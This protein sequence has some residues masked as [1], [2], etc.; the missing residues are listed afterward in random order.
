MASTNITTFPGKVGISNANPTHTLAIG[1][2]VF[3]DDT[4]VNKLVVNGNIS[5]TGQFTGDGVG[6][7]NIQTSNV[8]GL[9]DNVTRIG[10]LETDLTDNVTRIG[11]LETDLTDNVTRIGTL[12]TDLSDNSSR[13]TSI[14]S[15]EITITGVKTFQDDIILESNLRVQ[16][17]LLVANTVNMTV[18][19]PILELGSNNLN[20]G[21]VGLVM[22][23]HGSANSNVAI[24]FDESE[25]VLNMGY[26]LSG[27][28]DTTIEL[29]SNALAVNIQGALTA[30]SV[31]GDGSGLTNIQ[32]SN[33][34]DFA[35]NVARITSLESGDMTIDGEKTFSS[36]LE[37]G[38]ANL[39]VD[40][41]TGFVGVGTTNPEYTL[42]VVGDVTVSSN[43]AV[44]GSKFTYDNT[45]TIVFTGT[46]ASVVA[47]E[48]GY[49]D[50][51][52]SSTSNNIRVKIFIQYTQSGAQGEAEYSY[53]IRPNS[54]NSSSIYDYIN[55]GGPITPV[56]YRTDADDLYS[57][58]TP[59]VVRFGYSII[60]AQFVNWR[61]EVTQRSNN[62][63]FYPT[64]TGLAVDGT[65]LIQVTPAPSTNLNSNLAVNTDTL[66]VD[67]TTGNVGI[68]TTNP[69]SNLH[70]V[71]DINLTS[72]I[73][74]SG[75]VFV[76]AHDATS[77]YVA[78][79]PG[80]GQTEQNTYTIAIGYQA[81]QIGQ[82][83]VA[84]AVGYLAGQSGQS[85]SAIAI[86]QQA[87]E[88]NQG[89]RAVAIGRE[90][91]SN[92]QAQY[93]IAIGYKAGED[94]QGDDAIAVGRGAGQNFQGTQAV[95][96]GY[97]AGQTNQHDNTVVI[98]ASGSA[99]NTEGTGRTY[100]KPLRVA[101]VASNVMTYDQTTGEVMDSGGLFTNRLAVV[102]E[103]PPAALTYNTAISQIDGHGKYVI[104]TSRN[105]FNSS[106]G[107]STSAFDPT[108]G[109]WWSSG[110][111]YTNG[112]ANTS[113]TFSSLTDSGGTTH[114][115]AWASLKLP[116]KT[117]LRHVKMNQRGHSSGPSTFP[118]AVTVLGSNDDGAT[119][120]LIQNAISVPSAA[121]YT[122]TQIVVDASEKYRTYYFS[123]PTL[124][125]STA[126][127]LQ[128]GKIRLFT[129]SFSV[130]GGIMTSTA[131]SDL[132][133]S[134]LEVT[135]NAYVSSNLTVGT[136]NL[137]V[138]TLTGRIGVG[139]VSPGYTLDVHGTSN[140]G[141]L[142]VT[143]V[144]GNGSGLT[145]L[146]AD[147]LGS[148]TVPSARLSLVASDIPSLDASKITAGTLNNARLNNASTTGAGIVQ[149]SSSTSGS[150]TTKAA[151]ESAVKA[152]Y[153]RSSW[154]SGTFSGDLAVSG[155]L[156]VSGT[157]T[158]V[159]TTNLT[160]KDTIVELGK[161]NT[162]PTTDLG[163]IMRRPGSNVG[164][165]YDGSASK[166]EIGHTLSGGS[167]GTVTMDTSNALAVNVNGALTATSLSGNG[168]GLTSLNASNLSSGNVPSARLSL[169]ASDIPSLD[170]GKITSGTLTRP[171]NT[172]TGVF[173]HVSLGTDNYPTLGGNWL[174]IF[175]PTY[176]GAIGDNHPDP[177]GGILFANRSG[178]SRFPWGYYMG[179][180][181]DVASTNSTSLRFDIGKSSDLNSQDSTGGS[182]SLT[183]YLTIDNGN[184]GIGKTS[185]GYKLDVNGTVNTG[186]LTATSGTFS[187]N[188]TVIGNQE[189]RH[190]TTDSRG[191]VEL[192]FNNNGPNQGS[193]AGL[194]LASDEVASFNPIAIIDTWKSGVSGAPPLVFKT[195]GTER[196]RL[197]DSGN[198]GI[199]TTSPSYKL[200][201]NG[202]VNTGAL[203]ATTGT[204]SDALTA[205][206]GTFTGD[207]RIPT[208]STSVIGKISPV[209]L[210]GAG[211]N[212]AA[213]NLVKIGNTTVVNGSARGL[214]LTIITASTH[215]HVSSTAYDTYGS[216]GASGLLAT[217]LEGLTD[218]QIGILTS[219]DAYAAK[220]TSDLQSVAHKLGL[221]RLASSRGVA[222][223]HCYAS[224]FYGLGAS[225][226][227]GNHAIEVYKGND[228]SGAYATLSTFLV[229]DSF[230]GQ[231]VS[232]AL[233]SGESN[234]TTPSV[235]VNNS[236][237]V[238][239]GTTSP[240]AKL[241]I[242]SGTSGDC[243]LK[244]QADTDNN[245]E[246]DNPRIEFITDGA[247][248]TAMI[249]AGQMP[250]DTSNY[251]SLV[252]AALTM[253]FYTGV[254]DFTDETGM[255][256]RMIIN[257]DGNVGIGTSSPISTLQVNYTEG[258]IA[259]YAYG[260]SS[261]SWYNKG[262]GIKGG[263]GGFIYGHDI[264]HSIFLRRSPNGGNNDHN[265]YCNPGFHAFYTG[266]Y[267]ESQTEK[268]RIQSN[269]DVGIGTTSPGYKLDV[270]GTVNTGALTATSGTF[271]GNVTTGPNIYVGTNTN[272][273]TAKTI[274][275]GGTYGDNSYDH[276]VI[277]RRVYTTGTEK[278]ELLLFSGNDG[279]TSA[280]PDR[281]RLKGAQILFDTLNSSTDRTTEN[282]K[283]IIKAGGNVG[284]GTFS[285]ALTAT[286][287]TFSGALTA[288]SEVLKLSSGTGTSNAVALS[289]QNFSSSYTEIENGFGSR[290]QFRTNR[291]TSGGS[292]SQSAEIKGYIYG[293]A[294]GSGD[295][296]ALDLDAYGDNGSFSRG[297]SIYGKGNGTS[298]LPADVTVHGNLTVDGTVNTGALT[299]TSGTFSGTV[300]TGALTA[301]SGT[302]SGTSKFTN[303]LN[304]Q[305]SSS[306]GGQNIFTGYRT[307][308]SYGRA[309]L[310][311]SSAYSDIIIASSQA[312]NNHGSTLSFVAYNT[313]NAADYRK[314]VINQG[315]WGSRKQFLDFGY[316]DIVDPNPHVYINTTNTVLTLDGINKRVGIK[317]I[318]PGHNLS[319]TGNAY[320][321]SSLECDGR[322]YADDGCHVR[323][324]WLR[325]DGNNGIYFE[326]Y[327]GGW[328]MTDTTW[329]RSYNSKPIWVTDHIHVHQSDT[330]VA[331]LSAYG[332]SQGTGRLYVG[333]SSTY[334][335]GIEYNGD[336]SPTSTGAGADYITLYRVNNGGYD[337]T[338]RNLYNSNDW[339]FRGT[340]T[341]PTFSGNATSATTATTAGSASNVTGQSSI[342]KSAHAVGAND[343]HLELFAPA[344]GNA[345]TDVSLRFHQGGT[346]WGQLRYRG[347]GFYFTDGASDTRVPV[348]TGW[349]DVAGDI[350]AVGNITAYS[351]IRKKKNLQIID[352]PIEKVKKINGYTYEMDER[353]YTGLVAQE[354]LEVLPEA[355][356]G[357]EENGYG[358]AYGNMAG[359]FVEA[360]KDMIKQLQSEKAK[361]ET[362]ET[363]L[364]SVLARVDALE[365]A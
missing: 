277:E 126:T 248:N 145:S 138:D 117:T 33:V 249:G 48:I 20:T 308:D 317:N 168:S 3:V 142:T 278:Q 66:F 87:G 112:V 184:V 39:F 201:V 74:M 132:A 118:S 113:G 197:T 334:G 144:S 192:R 275:F 330:G 76:K 281:I 92:V 108:T 301:T 274:Y 153:D 17:D 98:N 109:G 2:N 325:V 336:N 136:A 95:A 339:E 293:G 125:G 289:I 258:T 241:H 91:G 103:Q 82:N 105:Q 332:D 52:T 220:I 359:L 315:N 268:M 266:G 35:S 45:N 227:S 286:T 354:V 198:F 207:V 229:D 102:S 193:G 67:T 165:I 225:T 148:G 150:S 131:V 176:D 174:T 123:F 120:V 200:D 283:M 208:L 304:I 364:A 351:D 337:W 178:S 244:L 257:D 240:S 242:S 320:I 284:T 97:L 16:G 309:Q 157:T 226:I 7:S 11:T 4:G 323:G 195:Q 223:R 322:I 263:T 133:T 352:T 63:T 146:N 189:I 236:G 149:L 151:T 159:D 185:P 344:S 348:Y 88:T 170:A 93:G 75:E 282:T 306:G 311:L 12:E 141:A 353:R 343:Y 222:S 290:I 158:T 72:N 356:V 234:D 252:L 326:S 285:G 287:G 196:M 13:I 228:A 269:G 46:N 143:S 55:K 261:T 43:L 119:K 31:N 362:L 245:N 139:T 107:N 110:G 296:H 130:D 57:G 137:H 202:T 162:V 203:T 32:S 171:I 128:V 28:N 273:E 25:D 5:A 318:N 65:G 183:P 204:F 328:H 140:V 101:T 180:V 175:S 38:T 232:N 135:G 23:R 340:V 70:V 86:G 219:Y 262:L 116:Y 134:S 216:T 71:G 152:A 319:V 41:T 164:I 1:S 24:V 8:I 291:G 230:C 36:N 238:G 160:I 347:S 327:G 361:V 194:L 294:G 350:Y 56:V 79:G 224:I 186:A 122:D 26:T 177:D 6:L 305:P 250:F 335:G 213:N 259:D 77:N 312:N 299:A 307:S 341:A 246:A 60:T 276:C 147:N 313:S 321:S 58:G 190:P 27:A 279:E 10:T 199:G 338:A 156:T 81:G 264:N 233:Y 21:D 47:S 37:V 69:T 30:A 40:T 187:G 115:G 169:V 80:A 206:T 188:L 172:S 310:V 166:L 302:F 270:N 214:T 62:V 22:T 114:Y 9:T 34:N 256:E 349:L 59:G 181:K 68:G 288:T 209:Y 333:Q 355:V 83:T 221:T 111:G 267:I 260:S 85:A 231:T 84:L 210:R 331:T 54:A 51:S 173:T 127:G 329:V 100:I 73:V 124:Q 272:N 49:L 182:D 104:D 61:V 255:L 218:D 253:R 154:G 346:Y 365:G 239:I 205:T 217:A 298:I 179:V 254:Q 251:N 161:D 345:N 316:A 50:M 106:S 53:Y 358:L 121:T 90:S 243:V 297:I 78:I 314:F 357:D 99:L 191:Y 44:S 14:E 155:D 363:Q 300:N 247:Y 235:L 342:S 271:S 94:T 129:E 15:G 360:M 96:V 18:S 42:D 167:E 324:D 211:S 292:T 215:V 19:D 303:I 163:I 295:Y 64:N 29:D 280:G 89:L 212:N 237:N 265:A